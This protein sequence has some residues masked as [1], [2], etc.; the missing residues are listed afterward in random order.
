MRRGPVMTGLRSQMHVDWSVSRRLLPWLGILL[1]SA[2]TTF[3]M[4][5]ALTGSW[6]TPYWWPAVA[7]A[8]P[9]S[10]ARAT[11]SAAY[12]KAVRDVRDSCTSLFGSYNFFL[13]DKD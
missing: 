8:S 2:A 13:F 4:T 3:A 11:E 10:E 6:A 1:R 5:G 7:S 12:E 9:A